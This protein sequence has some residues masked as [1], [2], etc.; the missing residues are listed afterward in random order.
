MSEEPAGVEK[1]NFGIFLLLTTLGSLIWNSIFV[2]AGYQ[3]GSDW[4]K[5]EPY[6]DA[7]QRIV[8]VAVLVVVIAFVVVR[9]RDRRRNPKE[10]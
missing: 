1:M 10:F 5:V 8:I 2:V 3:L 7:F 9:V 4:E 6:A